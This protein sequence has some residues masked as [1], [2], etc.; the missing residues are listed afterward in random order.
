MKRLDIL[1]VILALISL[2]VVGCKESASTTKT[3]ASTS[4]T[5]EEI[6]DSTVRA[7]KRNFESDSPAAAFDSFKKA[8]QM[9]DGKS[10]AEMV[11]EET[12]AYY[13]DVYQKVMSA[14][15]QEVQNLPIGEH[16][17]ILMSRLTLP[18]RGL[19]NMGSGHLFDK[20]G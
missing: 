11:S 17:M 15:S 1:V 9:G 3:T 7:I 10:A 16:I 12:M 14:S 13:S 4:K 8:V 18:D 5:P 2:T 20:F 6:A 19:K